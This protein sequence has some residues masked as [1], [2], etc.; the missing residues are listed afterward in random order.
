MGSTGSSAMGDVAECLAGSM[1]YI[2]VIHYEFDSGPDRIH[3]TMVRSLRWLEGVLGNL[4]YHKQDTS[5]IPLKFVDCELVMMID[6]IEVSGFELS[7]N[8]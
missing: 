2:V 4:G 1:Q 7:S 5:S 8:H 3:C 6:H